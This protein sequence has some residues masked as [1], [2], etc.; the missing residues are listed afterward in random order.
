M[1]HFIF[2]IKLLTFEIKVLCSLEI[3]VKADKQGIDI[4]NKIHI[5]CLF[6]IVVLANTTVDIVCALVRSFSL[7]FL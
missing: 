4:V 2:V 1:N 7:C 6:S 3:K 5:L